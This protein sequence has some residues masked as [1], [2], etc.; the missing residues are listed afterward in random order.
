ML[1]ALI[2]LAAVSCQKNVP[3]EPR[4]YNY[5]LQGGMS[6]KIS[7]GQP[8]GGRYPGLWGEDDKVAVVRTSDFGTCCTASLVEGA[9]CNSAS[10]SGTSEEAPGSYVRVMFPPEGVYGRGTLP[11]KQVQ[12][13][14]G[15]SDISKYTCAY[16]APLVLAEGSPMTFTLTHAVAIVKIRYSFASVVGD[17][18]LKSVM[19]S[20]EDR[21]LAGDYDMDYDSGL[22]TAASSGGSGS[23]ELSFRGK[24]PAGQD[25]NEVWCT[26]IPDSES[27]RYLLTLNFE[28][29]G[30]PFHAEVGFEARFLA[31][32]V[33]VVNATSIP[34]D[35]VYSG[36]AGEFEAN[37]IAIVTD[38][39][40]PL[41]PEGVEIYRYPSGIDP[42][43][44]YSVS[45]GG[46]DVL[47]FNVNPGGLQADPADNW[48]HRGDH[49]DEP[50]LAVFGSDESVPVT[51]RFLKG[52]PSK[53]EVRPLSKA[54]GYTLSGDE[55]T[56]N[57]KAGDRVSIEPDGDIDSPLL[58]FVNPL[59]GEALAAAKADPLTK[60]YT[61]GR[62]YDVGT[63]QL[64]EYRRVYIQGGAVLKGCLFSRQEGL[65]DVSVC[66]CGMIDSRDYDSNS[67]FTIYYADGVEVRNLT[68]LNRKNWSFRLN[69]VSN[70]NVDNVKV[71]AVCPMNDNWDE[72]DGIHLLGCRNGSLTRCFAYSWDDA[73]NIGTNFQDM[74]GAETCGVNVSD[75]VAWNVH[76]GNSF[77]FGWNC[78][79]D[80]HD[81]SYTDCY[82]IHS[83]TKGS[84]N[85]RAGISIHNNG[86]GTM[87]RLRYENIYIEDPME[88]GIFL[89]II[90]INAQSKEIGRVEDLTFKN[91]YILRQPPMGCSIT[92]YDESHKIENVT[93]DG[94][95]IEGRKIL[96]CED[97]AFASSA[98]PCTNL[99][100]VTFK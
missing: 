70:F 57:L 81:Q 66:G 13:G 80:N 1:A 27:R 78:A 73:F 59:E 20:C 64:K 32:T 65:S 89:S 48:W 18:F 63:L 46:F 86:A 79:Y 54:Y 98:Y 50:H 74:Y 49:G 33:N 83:G 75:A 16:S 100:N 58:L 84:K 37:G 71:V 56:I 87:S 67:A 47:A 17:S 94:L 9:G 38:L 45:V 34:M 53:V 25:E 82:A 90:H 76:P 55:L 91:I 28:N 19:L 72:N 51:V 88:H 26:V 61:A 15:C 69:L 68:V 96:S 39:D 21:A 40:E 99:N 22:L 2:V 23:V 11:R 29:G 93:F 7:V 35:K 60:V 97:A 77:E 44:R 24:V 10:F 36:F 52:A 4:M 85:M 62:F 42:S 8:D 92:G 5:V 12:D 41:G 95:F 43:D 31:N 6:T 30:S 3:V 14:A